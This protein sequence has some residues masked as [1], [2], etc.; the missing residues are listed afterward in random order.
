MNNQFSKSQ[1]IIS[2][3]ASSVIS[4]VALIYIVNNFIEHGN[5]FASP[6]SYSQV[7]YAMLIIVIGIVSVIYNINQLKKK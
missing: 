3:I 4:L 7:F 1:C 5:I 2:L 6:S